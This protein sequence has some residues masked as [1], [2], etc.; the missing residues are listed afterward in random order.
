MKHNGMFL[1]Q[2]KVVKFAESRKGSLV[3]D[4]FYHGLARVIATNDNH[5]PED[6]Y[7]VVGVT[8]L[9]EGWSDFISEDEGTAFRQT[10]S[11]QVYIVAKS[12]GQRFKVLPEDIEVIEKGR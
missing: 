2:V 7:T 9:K 8:Q 1:A 10:D 11:K 5:N 6:I 12:I 4:G 3:V